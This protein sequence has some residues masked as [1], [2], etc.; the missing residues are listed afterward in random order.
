MAEV[1][2]DHR[3]LSGPHSLLREV[4]LELLAQQLHIYFQGKEGEY[5]AVQTENT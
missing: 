5:A 2:R 1:E 4:L 3:R